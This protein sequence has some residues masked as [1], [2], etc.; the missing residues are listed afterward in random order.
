MKNARLREISGFVLL[1]CAAS[2]GQTNSGRILGTIRDQTGAVV[3]GATIVITDLERGASRRVTSNEV[4]EYVAADLP[5]GLYKV[6]VQAPN[7]KR[8]E[9]PS[10]RLEVARDVHLDLQLHPGAPN[11]VVEVTDEAPLVET[12]NDTLGGTFTNKAINDLPLNGR[13]FQNLVVLRPGVQRYPGGGFLSIS[14]NGNL[15]EDNNVIIDGVDNNDPYYASTVINAEGVQGTPATHLP[16]DAIQEFNAQEN[17][18]A[19]YGWKPG[20]TINIGLKSGT[21]SLH[22]ST[23]YFG[24]NSALDARNWFNQRPDP[25]HPLRTHQF[26]ATIGGPLVP[27]RAFYF[28]A[29]EGVRAVIGN[30]EIL[31]TPVTSSLGAVPSARFDSIPD[32][33][34]SLSS[35]GVPINSISSTLV[36]LFPQNNS[37]STD[38]PLGFPNQT[39]ED[40]GL[41]KLD[42]HLGERHVLTARYLVGDSLQTERDIPVLRPEWQSQ[43]VTR[44]QLAGGTWTWTPASR[45]ANEAKFGFNR[46]WQTILTVDHGRD[47]QTYGINTG[48]TDPINFGMPQISIFGFTP[49]GGNPNWPLET[50]PSQTLQGSDNVSYI[51]GRHTLRFGGEIRHGSTSNL[52]DRYGKGRIRFIGGNAWRSPEMETQSSPLEDFLA[53]LPDTG[54]IFVGDSRR[55]VSLKSFGAYVQ[56]D[57]RMSSRF[58]MNLGLRYELSSTIRER[59]NLLGNFDPNRGLVQVA[60][61]VSTPYNIDPNNFAPRVS[62]AWDPTGKSNTVIRA[63]AGIAYAIP[64]IS[65]FIGPKSLTT[66]AATEGLNVVPTG[67]AGV[68][69]GGGNIVAAAT[70]VDLDLSA[71][72]WSPS[73]PVFNVTNIDCS[74]SPCDILGVRRNLETPYVASWNFNIQQRLANNMSLQVAYV[75]NKG[76]KLYS[77]YDINQV[78]PARD[79][80]D[81]QSGR[82]L[83]YNCPTP[84]VVGPGCFPFLRFVNFLSNGYESKYHALQATL[85][86]RSWRGLYFLA[87]YTWSHALDQAS[88]NRP[89]QPQDSLH[90]EREYGNSDFDLRQRFTLSLTY[91]LPSREGWGQLLEG[92]QINSIVVMQTGLP[93]GVIDGYLGGNDVSATGEFSDRWNFTG[94]PAD[95]KPSPFGPIAYV[96]PADFGFNKITN[97]VTTTDPNGQRC[98]DSAGSPAAADAL[99][100]FGCYVQ[101]SGILTP[102]ARGTFG[103]M[104]R[105]IFRG[106]AYRNWDF[107]IVKN[108]RIGDRIIAQVRGEFFNILNHPNFSNP[109][110]VG[111]QL[112]N[113]DPSVPSFFGFAS[114]TPDVAAANPVMG[115]G[116]PRAIQI[117]LKLRF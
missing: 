28:L 105:N 43:A 36:A 113:V 2:L 63:G 71:Q 100:R 67:A 115:S 88:L 9:R 34:A 92:W 7:F 68:T 94:N 3:A 61:D 91:E 70:N 98:I 26:G 81:E 17:P 73:N 51:R 54:R 90:P 69:P 107:S 101:G 111:G 62:F 76:T 65:T 56:D 24:R 97:Q 86:E 106:P 74:A 77:V 27:N 49:L 18:S 89:R 1:C 83:T 64:P 110:G 80:G 29:Y 48:I 30:S 21:N 95:F 114:A 23:Y 104:R 31:A 112:G 75:G 33:M 32:A 6:S 109:Y 4:G 85:T 15:P 13:D 116:G 103:T 55:H 93:W 72:T 39:R 42:F 96:S 84:V 25:Q 66:N 57:L 38:I 102:P 8:A 46:F 19:E 14:S 22:G 20:A 10:T 87:G 12:T 47:P 52:R 5:P 78:D 11:E 82:P 50:I 41:A 37:S 58:V 53:G 108:W 99:A 35:H 60:R 44:A 59:E 79:T 16:I 45:W 117:G 40:N